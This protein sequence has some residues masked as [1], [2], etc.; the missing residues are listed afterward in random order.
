MQPCTLD[1]T[2]FCLPKRYARQLD[3]WAGLWVGST[4]RSYWMS[5]SVTSASANDP[6][7]TGQR[8]VIIRKIDSRIERVY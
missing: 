1:R 2:W 4:W 7:R 6:L 8:I 3:L 5:S